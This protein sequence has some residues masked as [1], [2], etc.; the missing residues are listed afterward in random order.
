[1]ENLNLPPFYPGQ[2]VVSLINCIG[3]N[4]KK[5][6]VLTVYCCVNN[7]CRCNE[8]WAVYIKEFQIIPKRLCY[9]CHQKAEA[10]EPNYRHTLAKH[11]APL[12]EKFEHI[13]LLKVIEIET[14]LV[15]EN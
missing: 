2:K 3:I 14:C 10:N 15:S 1:M 12:E 11:L 7:V 13:S 5:G 8:G 9:T 6:D 4:L